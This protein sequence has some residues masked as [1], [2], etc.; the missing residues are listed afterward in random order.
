[1]SLA[2]LRSSLR[3][4]ALQT[5]PRTARPALKQSA[6]RRFSTETPT[7]T[8]TPKPK[9]NAALYGGIGAAVVGGIALYVFTSDSDS[10]KAA[11]SAARSGAQAAKAAANFVPSK[12]D[13]E[14]VRHLRQVTRDHISR[15]CLLFTRLT[16]CFRS[17]TPLFC[18][19]S[20]IRS[21]SSLILRVTMTVRMSGS[22]L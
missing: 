2:A 8:P 6:F 13:Y 10:A 20:I 1:M 5:S 7:P 21:L 22:H 11:G 17:L 9:S 4:S 16:A 15:L 3:R 19:R 18:I 14:K 12:A